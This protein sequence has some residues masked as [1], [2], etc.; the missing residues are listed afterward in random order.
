MA[1]FAEI[2]DKLESIEERIDS[3]EEVVG[4][5]GGGELVLTGLPAAQLDSVL[6]L[7]SFLAEDATSGSFELCAAGGFAGEFGTA[8]IGEA[9][10]EG[11]GHLGAWAGTGAYAGGKITA[12]AEVA[13]GIK[14][15]GALGGSFCYPLFAGNPAVRPVPGPMR[16]PELD[17]L[18]TTLSTVSGQFGMDEDMLAQ[19]INGIGAAIGS[20]GS[21]GL[22]NMGDHLP[23]PPA[24][25]N[26][27]NDPV[28]TVAGGLQGLTSTAQSA[29]CSGIGWGGPVS[30][31]ISDACDVIGNG[32]LASITV[33]SDIASTYPA[34]QATVSTA[35]TRLNT[36]GLQRLIIPSWD[37]TF[38]LGIGTVNV[39]PGYN[40]RLF[41][42]YASF[43]CS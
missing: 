20:P 29:L 28:G 1:M 37:V 38:P 19:S 40:Q 24:L 13:G 35:C 17:Q 33:L 42:N 25:S 21:L 32:G 16:A 6:A 36:I 9:E 11:A 2:I 23:L 27:A 31:V 43:A 3:L 10:G 18:R 7:A 12:K 30:T 41:P 14:V 34:V 4:S 5:S 26:L 39:F 8:W 22:A 15:E